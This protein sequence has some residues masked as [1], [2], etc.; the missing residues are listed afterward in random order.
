MKSL[1][2]YIHKKCHRLPR[3]SEK[4]HIT[5]K[6]QKTEMD[7]DATSGARAFNITCNYFHYC[8]TLNY[9]QNL[10]NEAKYRMR[11]NVLLQIKRELLS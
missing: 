2:L 11:Q 8:H 3:I 4:V 1:H 5:V 10:H 6:F 9:C 7:K